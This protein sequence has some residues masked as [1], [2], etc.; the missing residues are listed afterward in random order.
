MDINITD[1]ILV[2]LQTAT[3][4]YISKIGSTMAIAAG[5]GF[6]LYLFNKGW[7]ALIRNEAIDLYPLLRPFVIGFLC[8]NFTTVVLPTLD[9]FL[10]P[11][12]NY[13]RT[14]SGELQKDN[15][16]TVDAIKI[17]AEKTRGDDRP[18]EGSIWDMLSA[19]WTYLCDQMI[20]GI[21]RLFL[22]LTDLI[23]TI[24]IFLISFLRVI[25]LV[26][27][28]MIGPIAFALS[29]FPGFDNNITNWLSKYISIY[30]WLPIGHI[31]GA[32]LSITQTLLL[33]TILFDESTLGISNNLVTYLMLILITIVTICAYVCIPMIGTWVVAGGETAQGM[34]GFMNNIARPTQA[35]SAAVGGVVG[36]GL[37]KAS[38][39]SKAG[40]SKIKSLISAKSNGGAAGEAGEADETKE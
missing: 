25:F 20:E 38:A 30:L 4:P 5:I 12:T 32:L 10:E 40:M 34:T 22:W 9:L 3:S 17:K 8:L 33:D 11:I 1:N 6:L 2:A 37:G 28:G 13:T 14:L 15:A 7:G 23:Q 36:Y 19:G 31:I 39:G 21:L 27:L 16:A 26:I 24:I 35:A 18:T 29:I